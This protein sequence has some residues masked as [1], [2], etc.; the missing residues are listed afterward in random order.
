MLNLKKML[1]VVLL[2]TVAAIA[3]ADS[4]MEV[5]DGWVRWVP[6]VSE[7][8]AAYFTLHNSSDHALDILSASSDVAR[9]VELH[10]VIKTGDLMQMQMQMQDKVVVPAQQS[11]SFQP[12]SYHVMLIGLHKP[13]EENQPVS[14]TL[15]FADGKSLQVPLTVRKDAGSSAG[16]DEHQHHHH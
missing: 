13:L 14:L 6:P 5:K 4:G 8:S 1:S 7:N 3:W 16:G 2:W 15:H 10:N 11:L 9:A 12:G